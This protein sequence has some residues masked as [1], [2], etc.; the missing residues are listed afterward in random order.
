VPRRTVIADGAG[1]VA[2]QCPGGGGEAAEQVGAYNGA[3]QYLH[4]GE[5]FLRSRFGCAIT[6]CGCTSSNSDLLTAIVLWTVAST[7]AGVGVRTVGVGVKEL[8]CHKWF[9]S[10]GPRGRP[11]VLA[12]FV[13]CP[14]WLLLVARAGG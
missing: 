7:G 13:H 9:V 8:S 10:G 14:G 2:G 5:L 12:C 4:V 6:Q 11:V 3:T 1:S